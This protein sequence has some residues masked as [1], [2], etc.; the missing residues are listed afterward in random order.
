[1]HKTLVADELPKGVLLFDPGMAPTDSDDESGSCFRPSNMPLDPAEAQGWL[2]QSLAFGEQFKDA[3]DIAYFMSGTIDDHY[4]GTTKDIESE[5]ARRERGETSAEDKATLF[6]AQTTLLLAW[7]LEERLQD[8]MEMNSSVQQGWDKIG[9]TLGLDEEEGQELPVV[10]VF[11]AKEPD[12]LAEYSRAWRTVLGAM[13]P[14]TAEGDIFFTSNSAVI[15]DLQEF[16]DLEPATFE[17][18]GLTEQSGK[19]CRM[20]API[21]KILKVVGDVPDW[22]S[23]ER[24]IFCFLPE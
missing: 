21:K 1:M 10:D 18:A 23:V 22:M 9:E 7:N 20:T 11:A 4:T 16:F 2:Q 14:L 19:L 5:L 3:R 15:D 13:V 6:K 8:M 17:E 12:E 24:T